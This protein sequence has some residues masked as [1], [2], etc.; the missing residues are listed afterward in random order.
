MNDGRIYQFDR[1]YGLKPIQFGDFILYQI[2]EVYGD[3]GF[4]TGLHQQWCYEVTY[5]ESGL[6][7]VVSNGGTYTAR[8]GDIV[9]SGK[10]CHHEILANQGSQ[11]RY[12]YI[13]FDV[14][15]EKLSD[16]TMI[17]M[18]NDL[19]T[20]KHVC[21]SDRFGVGDLMRKMLQ[22]F[23]NEYAEFKEVVAS[24]MSL[25]LR[26]TYRHGNLES[27][28]VPF[29]NGSEENIG[30]AV[31]RV[32]RYVD[33]H[34]FAIESIRSIAN[35]LNYNYSYLSF[36]FKKH[37]GVTLQKYIAN[38]KMERAQT[39]LLEQG[40][41]V[42]QVAAALGYKNTQAFSKVFNSIYNV[43][44]STYIKQHKEEEFTS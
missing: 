18:L 44:P 8:A 11:L 13:G 37:T 4:S 14:V 10:K 27:R 7:T 33:D 12:L 26:L 38:K 15:E 40:Q 17:A 9:I 36:M 29:N 32:I 43:S 35:D 21:I 2:G 20:T 34:L 25:I 30:A 41:S 31:Y 39:M 23:Y 19:D 5:I 22:E 28:P 42:A 24:Y 3:I 1:D 6:A 16:P